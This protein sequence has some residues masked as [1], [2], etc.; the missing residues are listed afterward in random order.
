MAMID[1]SLL[2]LSLPLPPVAPVALAPVPCCP[3]A[4]AIT[5]ALNQSTA[6]ALGHW[7]NCNGW[8]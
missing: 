2:P 4:I 5:A 7:G 6:M 8:R 3:I 1:Q